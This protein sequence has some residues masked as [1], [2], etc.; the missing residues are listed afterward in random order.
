MIGNA[1][2]DPVWLW[3][4]PEGYQEVRASFQSA[5]DRLDEYPEYVFT[6]DSALFF[7][8][9]SESDPALLERIR[10]HVADG[11]FEIV[12]GWWIEPDCNI[13]GGESFVRQALYGQRYLREHFGVTATVGANLDSFGHNASLPQIL[14]KSGC[15]SYVFLRP[16]PH[17]KKL[18][19]PLFWWRSPDGSRVLA[20]RIPHEYCAP[21]DDIGGHVD[22]AI[23]SLP[24]RDGEW[25]VFYGV[26][27]HGGGPTKANLEQIRA[28]DSRG[29][30]PKLE[31]SS[32]RRF[33]DRAAGD[34]ELPTVTGELQHH[35]P[36]CYTTH[37]EIKRTNRRAESLLARAERW[38]AVADWLEL[39]PYP[40]ADLERAWKL[41]LF[42]QFHDTLAGTSIEPAYEDARDQLGHACS[43][44]AGAFNAAVQS[45]AR[46][47]EI[48]PEPDTRPLVIFNPHPWAVGADVELEFPWPRAEGVHA[49]DEH[50]QPVPLQT[51]R[52]LATVSE[53]RARL[54]LAADLPP[55][56]YRTY[57]IRP[58]GRPVSENARRDLVLENEH[59]LL[60]LDRESGRIARL[61]VKAAGVDLA[62]PQAPHAVV[63]EDRSD[64]WG[65]GVRAYDDVAGEFRCESARMLETGPVRSILQ[66]HSRYGDSRLREDYVLSAHASHVDVRVTLD[67]HQ[68]L[69]M[70]KLRYPTGLSTAE[71]T[72]EIPYGHL[73]RPA[74]GDEEPGQSWV[75]VSAAG[76]GL[77]VITDAKYGYDVRGGDIGISAV[78]S[79][80]WAWHDPRELEPDGD[81]E[82]MDQGRQRFC[83]R[84]VPHAGDWR[85]AGVVRHAAELNQA[86]F[87]LLESA[88]AGSLATRASYADD[89]RGDVVVT[90]LK[91][92]EDGGAWVLRAHE[93]S[94]RSARAR[95]TALGTTLDCDFAPHEI[96]TF[97]D[98]RETDLLES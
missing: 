92:A 96:K 38:C 39:R 29:D 80:V 18:E 27:N 9:V 73:V 89:G 76:A 6:C 20:Y 74:G 44:A 83:V 24:E 63:V 37:S 30:L 75:D 33:F 53:P 70:L 87:A 47:I 67:W 64:T 72:F 91:R 25:A 90:V 42:N 2:I 45:I 98:G 15:D 69:K 84:L 59:L 49:V 36:G 35:A 66:V 41:V 7:A 94:G 78:R 81:F 85:A 65:H 93:S 16:Q 23:A 97:V 28:L 50:G 12:G 4:W 51:T 26:G 55:L 32:L 34:G 68:P 60:E 95:I 48:P 5:V 71:A 40:A 14:A 17:E 31:S 86:P 77:S 10:A 54:V 8:W 58:G 21:R 22:R 57:R 79:P 19:R 82:Y 46:Q 11:R 52:P 43:L 56:G 13:P 1:H 62:A 88:H 3:Q 61:I